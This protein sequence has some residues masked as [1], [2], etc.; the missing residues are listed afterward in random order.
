MRRLAAVTA[1]VALALTAC[2]NTANSDSAPPAAEEWSYTTGYENTITLDALPEVIVTDAYSAAALWEYGIRPDAVFGWGLEEGA[3]ELALG[4][5]E[6]DTMEVIG[7]GGELN[8][9]QLAALQPDLVIGYGNA[10]NPTSWTWWEEDVATKVNDIAPFAGVNFSGRPLVDVIEEYAGLAEALGADVAASDATRAKADFEKASASL[11]ETL[12]D[13]QDLTTIALNG[14]TSGLWV[15]TDR[16]AQLDLLESLGVNLV[17]PESEEAWAEVS[18]EKVP[19][20]PAD[21]VLTYV[22]S[23]DHFA[24]APVYRSLPAVQA[25][26]V[27]LWDDKS[28]N[29]YVHY[30]A[31]L[32]ELDQAYAAADKVTD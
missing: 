25:E 9:E 19:D 15:G 23:T 7:R 22:A 2:A 17:G 27:A 10:D 3:S 12:A 11:T 24:E 20:Y 30:A 13:K 26:Q 8:V 1:A 14:D 4:N 18:W 21:V 28:P 5:A 16:L 32:E 31:W 6:L 29:T